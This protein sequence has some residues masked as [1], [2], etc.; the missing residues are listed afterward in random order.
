MS[1][2]PRHYRARRLHG[3]PG[4]IA[5]A[6]SFLRIELAQKP[7]RSVE[8]QKHSRDLGISEWALKK[9][10]AKLGVRSMHV[11]TDGPGRWYWRLPEG[12]L[13]RQ[14]VEVSS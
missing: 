11:G 1:D 14:G 3:R 8:V 10:K 12:R 6:V 2:E 13:P 9:A 4:S 7:V 5:E